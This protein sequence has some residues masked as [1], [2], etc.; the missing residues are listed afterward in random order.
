MTTLFENHVQRKHSVEIMTIT[1]E[2]ARLWLGS[3]PYR[4]QR[5]L[6]A[7]HV[8]FLAEEMR[9]GRFRPTAEVVFAME[10]DNRCFIIN[11]NH[12]L[13]AI[14][15]CN[16]PQVATVFY[17]AS[18]GYD[19]TAEAYG[20]IDT[21]LTRNVNDL[22]AAMFLKDELGLTSTQLNRLGG[23]VKVIDSKFGPIKG[24]LHQD[25]YLRLLR[26]YTPSSHEYFDLIAGCPQEIYPSATRSA[27]MGVAL[28]TIRFATQVFGKDRVS[29][30]WTGVVFDD[31]IKSGDPRKVA[32]RHL[33][34]SATV[35]GGH[36]KTGKGIRVVTQAYSARYLANCFNAWVQGK[37][38][39]KTQV[40]DTSVPIKI[41]G[42][43]FTGNQ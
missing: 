2:Q 26:Q 33:E 32:N 4:G 10:D 11:G 15:Q 21:N 25:D 17:Y 13:N 1:P 27:S 22:F 9:R 35:G 43:P 29:D 37:S 14:I 42:T 36:R 30:F 6:R 24:R 8:Q 7:N 40:E 19:D 31:G 23:G 38:L 39:T 18:S 34:L 5:P 12:T 16:L 3:R 20:S 41:L 28:V